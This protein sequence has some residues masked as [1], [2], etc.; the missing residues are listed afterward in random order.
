MDEYAEEEERDDAEER[1]KKVTIQKRDKRIFKMKSI[2]NF[3]PPF[4]NPHVS[5]SHVIKTVIMK[6]YKIK[7]KSTMLST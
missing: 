7:S 5:F 6:N 3:I 2:L 4:K 1:K